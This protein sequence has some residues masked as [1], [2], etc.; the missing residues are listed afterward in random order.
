M[1]KITLKN[2]TMMVVIAVEENL[3]TAKLVSG[4]VIAKRMAKVIAHEMIL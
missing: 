4:T 3:P 1:V 2:V